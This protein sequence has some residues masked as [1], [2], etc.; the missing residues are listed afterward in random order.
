VCAFCQDSQRPSSIR[1]SEAQYRAR[2]LVVKLAFPAGRWRPR[3]KNSTTED[4]LTMPIRGVLR[5]S[6]KLAKRK[7]LEKSA[8]SR[9]AQPRTKTRKNP[10]N[11]A[12]SVAKRSCAAQAEICLPSEPASALGRASS[13]MASWCSPRKPQ[14]FHHVHTSTFFPEKRTHGFVRPA[15]G[16][17]LWRA[18]AAQLATKLAA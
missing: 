13:L 9:G 11:A 15:I 2:R 14:F 3:N 17:Q 7:A 18:K 1:S 10:Q 16:A 6:P 5:T 12:S 8:C 4:D